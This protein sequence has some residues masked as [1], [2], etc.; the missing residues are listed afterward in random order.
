MLRRRSQPTSYSLVRWV[1]CPPETIVS[2]L[3]T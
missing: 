3:P 2:K 1:S